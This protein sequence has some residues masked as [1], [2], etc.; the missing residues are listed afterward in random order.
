VDF[1]PGIAD[2]VVAVCRLRDAAARAPD[3]RTLTT[4]DGLAAIDPTGLLRAPG[5]KDLTVRLV[6]TALRTE[7]AARLARVALAA[8]DLRATHGDF[9][10]SLDELRPMFPDGVPLDPY[11]DAPFVYERTAAGVRIASA[12]RLAGED[13]LDEATLRAQCL[14]WELRR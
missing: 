9:P 12:G 14:S 8:A 13:A 1:E 4:A 11:T 2:L 6:H 3:L 10:A 7:A 5:S